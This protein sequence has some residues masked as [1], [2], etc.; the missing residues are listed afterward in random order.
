MSFPTCTECSKQYGRFGDRPGRCPEC[1]A[2]I[3]AR[4]LALQEELNLDPSLLQPD[5]PKRCW[6]CHLVLLA[7]GRCP[8]CP[9]PENLWAAKLLGDDDFP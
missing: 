8:V 1:L 3:A 2:E 9:K 5:V 7:N 6:Q 4:D